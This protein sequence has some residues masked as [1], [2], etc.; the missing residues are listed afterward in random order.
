MK[1]LEKGS[2]E[3]DEV[4]SD[5]SKQGMFAFLEKIILVLE[6]LDVIAMQIVHHIAAWIGSA[7]ELLPLSLLAFSVVDTHQS[8]MDVVAAFRQ[9][10]SDLIQFIGEDDFVDLSEVKGYLVF[11]GS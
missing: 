10:A 6:A 9:Q 7:L 11:G 5:E 3:G 2:K 1:L 8:E 4:I